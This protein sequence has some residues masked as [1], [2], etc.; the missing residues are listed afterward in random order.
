[1][2]KEKKRSQK[3]R[4]VLLTVI[5]TLAMA[6]GA[7]NLFSRTEP[8]P[9][10]VIEEPQVEVEPTPE[11]PAWTP[12]LVFRLVHE[13]KVDSVAW[14]ND[15]TMFATGFFIQAN[16]WNAEDGSLVNE[17]EMKHSV[18]DIAFL[19]DDQTIATGVSLGGV[20]IYDITTG[21]P[22]QEFHGGY[23]NFLAL[24]PDGTL[25]AT[26]NR[27]GLVWLWDVQTGDQIVEI[28]SEDYQ[29]ESPDYLRS[30]AFS[31]DGQVIAAG[32]FDGAVFLWDGSSYAL[33]EALIPENDYAKAW[34]LAFSPDSQYLAVGGARLEWED[35]VAIYDMS[36]GVFIHLLEEYGRSG[37]MHAPVAFSPDGTLLAAGSTEGVYLWSVPNFE[38]LHYLPIED[39]EATDWVTDLAFSPDSQQLI[40]G[41][42]DSYALVWQIQPSE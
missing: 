29:D 18:E 7:C 17:I 22:V 39:L 41:Y 33:R 16:I 23:D 2:Q 37:S 21:E 8:T 31:P 5:L 42:W 1:M 24:S 3:I 10:A 40:A 35:V 11:E 12:E 15:G 14:S 28:N 32:H 36:E 6:S 26:G 38:L 20:N 25:I 9:E 30:L 34:G 13:E 19:P 4:T 27:S